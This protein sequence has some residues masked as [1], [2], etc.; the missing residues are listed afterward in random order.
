MRLYDDEGQLRWACGHEFCNEPG[1]ADGSRDNVKC[2]CLATHP[3]WAF[4]LLYNSNSRSL[5]LQ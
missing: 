4:I 5:D 1:A 3:L 2:V